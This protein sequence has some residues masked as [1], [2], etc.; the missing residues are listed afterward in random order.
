MKPKSQN[1]K[2]AVRSADNNWRN[3]PLGDLP[4]PKVQRRIALIVFNDVDLLDVTG[5]L[6]AF[7]SV[8][9]FVEREY[10][11]MP[12][13]YCIELWGASVGPVKTC[14]GVSL[15]AER[16]Y[17][18]VRGPID[19]LI[20][21]GGPRNAVREACSDRELMGLIR[22]LGPRVRRLTSVCTGAFILA[23]TG[24]LDGHT[25]ATH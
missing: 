1:A 21:P 25:V 16:T 18:Q 13:A 12:P 10:P 8:N 11:Q 24:L 5:P 6:S 17:G 22:R 2:R 14:T 15:V 19:T 20:V 4:R 7:A 3:G 9:R 23:E